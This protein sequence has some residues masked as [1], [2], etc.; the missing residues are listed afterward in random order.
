[1]I[2]LSEIR[3]ILILCIGSPFPV[4]AQQ[5]VLSN[6]L[7]PDAPLDERP[8]VTARI[9]L[10]VFAY[11]KDGKPITDLEPTDFTLLDNGQPRKILSF[12]R[13]IGP[14]GSQIDPPVQ[15][16]LVIDSVELG[17][18]LNGMMRL[19]LE[20]F[21][22]RDGGHLP[23]PTSVLIFSNQGLR[24]QSP[25]S[26]D[27]AALA[28]RLEKDV[29]RSDGFSDYM[30]GPLIEF[31][32]SLD[33]LSGIVANERRMPGKKVLIWLG[34][35]WPML[36]SQTSEEAR[37]NY[38]NAIV[39]LSNQLRTARMTVY[40]LFPAGAVSPLDRYEFYLRPVLDWHKAEAANL[41]PEV[42]ARH[43]GGRVIIARDD[44]PARIADC[45]VEA[46]AYY[47][48]TFDPP[49]A[50]RV[51][52]YHDLRIQVSRQSVEVRTHSGYYN[53]P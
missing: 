20:R 35:G 45:F 48:L 27:G 50:S 15:M 1:M 11:G 19:D 25:P 16:I 32:K 47:T 40:C 53:Q 4:F 18:N 6:L 5:N 41:V 52:E 51:N 24:V 12:R 46:G 13:T 14:S 31:R 22:R 9:S 44:M 28:N 34:R 23:F 37:K 21:L 33:A 7:A 2:Q 36:R 29:I 3:L 49:N 39:S 17:P 10:D 43:T 30:E 8:P 38:F 42:L 26:L